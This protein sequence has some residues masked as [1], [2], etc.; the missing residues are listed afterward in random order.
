MNERVNYYTS[1][2]DAQLAALANTD[3]T[4]AFFA[5]QLRYE[6]KVFGHLLRLAHYNIPYAQDLTGETF[7]EAAKDFQKHIYKEEKKLPNWLFGIS[8]NV[9]L[10][11]YRETIHHPSVSLDDEEHPIEVKE[12]K[13]LSPEREYLIMLGKVLH[14]CIQPVRLAFILG[15]IKHKDWESIGKRLGIERD[16]A[17]RKAGRCRERLREAAEK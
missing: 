2:S 9:Y 5:I 17:R 13:P 12:E 11:H 14:S 16:S 3:N 15:Y 10:N 6:K 8:N 4:D 7:D 1:L